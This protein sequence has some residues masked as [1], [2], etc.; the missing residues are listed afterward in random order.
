VIFIK[1]AALPIETQTAIL[2]PIKTQPDDRLC[3]YR[4]LVGPRGLTMV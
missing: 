2:P 3:E 4:S 1:A